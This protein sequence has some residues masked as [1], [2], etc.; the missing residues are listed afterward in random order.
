MPTTY[1][2]RIRFRLSRSQGFESSDTQ[3]VLTSPP[4]ER[5]ELRAAKR[6]TVLKDAADL[7]LVGKPY[8]SEAAALEAGLRWRGVLQRAFAYLNIGADF[9]DRAAGGGIGDHWRRQVR[10]QLGVRVL[11]DVH[12]VMAFECEP[13]PV[14]VS[15][16]GTLSS[17]TP[18]ERVLAACERAA[19]LGPTA[20]RYQLAYDLYS[21]SFWQPSPDAGFTMLMMAMEAMIDQAERSDEAREQVDRWITELRASALAENEVES[22]A[23]SLNRLRKES[24]KQ[25][26]RRLAGKLGERQYRDEPPGKFFSKC[27]DL[28]SRLVHGHYPRPTREEVSSHAAQLRLLV[29]HLLS[30][31]MLDE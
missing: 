5:V 20:D 3:L 22:L 30:F 16:T 11:Y 21:A 24:I 18:G 10:E 9:G 25:A 6:G 2:F 29:S 1:C 17:P 4:E 12:G 27:Y 13:W 7:I 23:G 26:G 28:R 15:A 19:A 8:A 31:E 14:F